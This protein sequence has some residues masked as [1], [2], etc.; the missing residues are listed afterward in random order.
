MTSGSELLC[1]GRQVGVDSD[2]IKGRAGGGDSGAEG[3]KSRQA[4]K[5]LRVDNTLVIVEVSASNCA[6][7]VQIGENRKIGEKC[8]L[9]CLTRAC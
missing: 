3:D 2:E 4:T 6:I 7:F 9:K 5:N 8:K 1:N